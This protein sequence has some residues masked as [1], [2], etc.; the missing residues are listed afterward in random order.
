MEFCA[1]M[2]KVDGVV[3]NSPSKECEPSVITLP[4]ANSL[5]T[6]NLPCVTSL[7]VIICKDQTGGDSGVLKKSSY[8]HILFII[9]L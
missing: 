5:A 3:D 8:S 9:W 1:I 2:S 7:R 6:K 4:L